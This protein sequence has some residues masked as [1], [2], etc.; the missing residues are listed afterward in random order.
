MGTTIR[1]L[2]ASATCWWLSGHVE[3]NV[4]LPL[5]KYQLPTGRN[6]RGDISAQKKLRVLNMWLSPRVEQTGERDQTLRAYCEPRQLKK[7]G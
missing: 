2:T 7:S 6:G 3:S 4:A 1:T 5:P